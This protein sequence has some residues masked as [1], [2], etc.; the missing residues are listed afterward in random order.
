MR[1]A[2]R[3]TVIAG[4]LAAAAI[5]SPVATAS[6]NLDTASTT[7]QTQSIAATPAV[8]P[9]RDGQVTH[10]TQVGPPALP[11][12]TA[13]QLREVHRGQTEA[14]QAFAY[15]PSAPARYSTAGLNGYVSSPANRAPAV[16]H[17][18]T[19]GK[20]FDWGAA[21][22]GAAAGLIVSLLILGAGVGAT[23]RR[24]AGPSRA[25]AVASERRQQV[26]A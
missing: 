10:V 23:R 6:P 26:R 20:P 12:P 24:Q 18:T 13:S 17:V 11:A 14:S 8:L 2:A 5:A 7:G 21:A 4:A 3:S 1:L 9:D 22:I 25:S 15:K 19:H 16:V